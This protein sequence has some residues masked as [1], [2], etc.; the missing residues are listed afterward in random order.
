MATPALTPALLYLAFLL[1]ETALFFVPLS[2][3]EGPI[4]AEQH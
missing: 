3:N 2:S 4:H 1:L